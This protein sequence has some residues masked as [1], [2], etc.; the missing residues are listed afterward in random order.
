MSLRQELKLMSEEKP[1]FTPQW[2]DT[3]NGFAAVKMREY[4][5]IEDVRRRFTIIKE[6]WAAIQR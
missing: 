2:D 6:E 3:F 5:K 4:S 1:K